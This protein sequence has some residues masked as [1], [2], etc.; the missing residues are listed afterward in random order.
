MITPG[1][2]DHILHGLYMIAYG[3]YMM[4]DNLSNMPQQCYIFLPLLP[5][6]LSSTLH[7]PGGSLFL[8]GACLR[9]AWWFAKSSCPLNG[10]LLP[11]PSDEH[12][13][14]SALWKTWSKHCD[15]GTCTLQIWSIY[16]YTTAIYF[17]SEEYGP[18][19]IAYRMWIIHDYV[20]L[21]TSI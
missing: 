17:F 18:Y 12:V 21:R 9:A 2:C 13:E 14:W 10:V 7:A 16:D 1:R 6:P 15:H 4:T 19:M 3:T 8:R 5:N 11:G 20:W